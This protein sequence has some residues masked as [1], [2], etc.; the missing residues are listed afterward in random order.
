MHVPH[1][2]TPKRTGKDGRN[3]AAAC[4]PNRSKPENELKNLSAEAVG[5]AETI[6]K[7]FEELEG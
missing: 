4:C 6:K 5:L 2:F 1:T 7:N 3:R